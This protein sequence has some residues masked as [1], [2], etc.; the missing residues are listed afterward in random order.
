MHNRSI[1]FA[2][3]FGVPIHVRSSFS[4]TEGTMIVAESE[5]QLQPV[6]GAAMTANEARIT[7]LGVPDVP[8]KSRDIFAAIAARKIAV[9][10]V[11]QNVGKAGRAD[12]SFTVPRNELKSTLQAVESV[13]DASRR[14][15][16][17]P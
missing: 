14:R 1:E 12:V 7:V 3:K 15:W 2:K 17:H 10:M 8:G 13:M 5:S 4:D 11:V 9:D 16:D 6:S